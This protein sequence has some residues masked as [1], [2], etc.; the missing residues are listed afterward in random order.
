MELTTDGDI[1]S[2]HF[3]V[4]ICRLIPILGSSIMWSHGNLV[5]KD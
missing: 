3:S 1:Y 5:V 2:S 4:Q